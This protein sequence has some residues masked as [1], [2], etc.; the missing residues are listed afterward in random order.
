MNHAPVVSM[1]SPKSDHQSITKF[2][3]SASNSHLWVQL[4]TTRCP[5]LTLES[6]HKA[7]LNIMGCGPSN[8]MALGNGDIEH[9]DVHDLA[10]TISENKHEYERGNF[11][12]LILLINSLL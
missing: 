12:N 3:I 1:F 11:E 7:V 6:P 4:N 8:P 2:L 10:K 5:S 9:G